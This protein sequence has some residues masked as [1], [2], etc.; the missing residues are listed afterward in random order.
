[1]GTSLS[2]PDQDDDFEDLAARTG[3]SL[4][5]IGNLHKRFKHLTN[6][7]STLRNFQPGGTGSVREITFEEFLI[8]MS[9]FRPPELNMTSEQRESLRTKKLRFLFNMYDKDN[10]GKITLQEYRHVVEE[11]L[12]RS[13]TIGKDTAKDIADAAML[14]VAS[15]TVVH[16]EPDEFYEGITFEHFVKILKDIEIESKMY[17]RFLNMD[18]TTL[19]K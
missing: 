1:M 13:G 8:V 14:E 7:Q 15:I 19:C 5:Q 11:L 12:S 2:A 17:V 4:E 16:M 3:F 18:T 10:D 9:H 6:N